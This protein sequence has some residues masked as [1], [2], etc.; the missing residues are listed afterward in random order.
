MT[1]GTASYGFDEFLADLTASNT[2]PNDKILGYL[3]NT[4]T[5]KLSNVLN[6]LNFVRSLNAAALA[7]ASLSRPTRKYTK[8]QIEGRQGNIVGKLLEQAVRVLLDGCKC[9]SHGGN[10]HTSTSEIDFL[11]KVNALASAVPALRKVHTHALGEAKCYASG[12]KS[13][14]VNELVGMMATHSAD[15][16]VLFL[17]APPKKLRIDHRHLFHTQTL[18][19]NYIIPFGVTQLQDVVAGKNFLQVLNEQYIE[20][21]T[22]AT[23]LSI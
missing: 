3:S 13:E 16:S 22:G 9:F 20:T 5:K 1:I 15:H 17:G 23:N 12:L 8:K 19:G 14:W 7:K 4:D 11:L 18:K 21:V 10:V 6:R 2:S